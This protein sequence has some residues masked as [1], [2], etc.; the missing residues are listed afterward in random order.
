METGPPSP[1]PLLFV[2]VA[3][4]RGTV[5][6]RQAA[7]AL[8][9]GWEGRLPG[10]A[11]PREAL[12]RMT[13]LGTEEARS[14][15]AA[16][17][18]ILA[19][20]GSPRGPASTVAPPAAPGPDPHGTDTEPEPAPV[21]RPPPPD[22]YR[23]FVPIGRGGMGVVYAAL[24][25]EMNRKVAFK[26]LKP[27]QAAGTDEPVTPPTPDAVRP[28][29]ASDGGRSRY[30][31]WKA[32]FLQE[33]WVAGGLEHP[34]IVP[35]HEVGCTEGGVPYYTMRL[36]PGHRTLRTAL[37]EVAGE[38]LDVRLSL[39]E[40]FLRACDAV[41]YAHSRGV[42]HRDLKPQNIALGEFGE[43]FVVDWGLAALAP[44]AP[45]A[46][47]GWQQGIALLR[48]GSRLETGQGTVG[49][50]GYA[51][52]ETY[53]HEPA[54]GGR[55]GDVYGLGVVLFEILTGVLPFDPREEGRLAAQFAGAAPPEAAILEPAVPPPLSRLAAQALSPDPARR[56]TD[57]EDLV[58]RIR[59]WQANV[60]KD[61]QV[62][63][64]IDEAELAI[65]TAR[66]LEG[67]ALFR[68]LERATTAC[69]RVLERVPEH[70]AATALLVRGRELGEAAL[71]RQA[72][73]WRRRQLRR[74]GVAA[75]VLL[76]VLGV[77]VSLLLEARRREAE[78]ARR[79]ATVARAAEARHRERAE[80]A[81]G[82][83]L[84]ELRGEL[85]SM[86]R[87]D[88]LAD[89]GVH[90]RTHYGPLP[91]EQDTPDSFRRRVHALRGLGDV[92]LAMGRL[93]AARTVFQEARTVAGRYAEVNDAEGIGAV[94][95]AWAE[96]EL[97]DVDRRQGFAHRS[98][99]R[100]GDVV[101]ALEALAEHPAVA[102]EAEI[103]LRAA[104]S[105]EGRA[106]LVAG[107]YDRAYAALRR[108][109][110]ASA[111]EGVGDGS[112]AVPMQRF[113]TE[114]YLAEAELH[115]GRAEEARR[116]I[117]ACVARA[118]GMLQADPE[119][120]P[121]QA[122]LAAAVA[123]SARF[124]A[125]GD[126]QSSLGA[127]EEALERYGALS[128]RHPENLRWRQ[129]LA[130]LHVRRGDLA[131][132]AKDGARAAAEFRTAHAIADDLVARDPTNAIWLN[133]VITT[134]DRRAFTAGEDASEV[135]ALRRAAVAHARTLYGLDAEN[136]RWKT[137][138]AYTI[139]VAPME[140]GPD[141][142]SRRI[143]ELQE[144]QPL[145]RDALV[146][147]PGP[148]D[149]PVI[150]VNVTTE[151]ARLQIAAHHTD[152]VVSLLATTFDD[153]LAL[154]RSHARPAGPWAGLAWAVASFA[155]PL[156]SL[157]DA[158]RV[159]QRREARLH[160]TRLAGALDGGEVTGEQAAV[161]AEQRER[162][163]RRAAALASGEDG[164]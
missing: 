67:D 93:P 68:Q 13:A 144:A 46:R 84:E 65:A 8:L 1:R 53:G 104:R 22:R 135:P 138:L 55:R 114:L 54:G 15:D 99:E 74:F 113:E 85:A 140:A 19:A 111:A 97:A 69:R 150:L 28:P 38:P 154:T 115:T 16:V 121:T 125:G 78:E 73:A 157:G 17:D 94:E 132:K 151:L 107:D 92:Y 96:V 100:L 23:D 29:P 70:A 103:V 40:P 134:C 116:R 41:R 124:D 162:A 133:L 30:D 45:D 105:I 2:D 9:A 3:L 159:E 56:P 71:G 136:P 43:T 61:R 87:L 130:R 52:P 66:D 102:S 119:D 142:P 101:P 139:F 156:G 33:A 14:I 122:R 118:R 90:A 110:P 79:A 10:V 88:L 152:A 26:I 98:L 82:F 75:L 20:R 137:I 123:A 5:T 147:I 80:L 48:R 42:V 128:R 51:A 161:L 50:P 76:V 146:A 86:G 91:V 109:L 63:R 24:D 64:W 21:L 47:D 141:G 62:R 18:A 31:G 81:M 112:D 83:M 44:T 95:R 129:E 12:L 11:D 60:Q 36:V 108:A 34:G 148:E 49:T 149:V 106:A 25:E 155:G 126:P 160:A 127:T 163:E 58:R 77:V 158:G 37:D 7:T 164:R 153:I 72:T 131:V 35:V 143:A 117:E 4:R 57:V 89:L 145:A 27:S 6:P 59:A 120:V 39:L 32:R